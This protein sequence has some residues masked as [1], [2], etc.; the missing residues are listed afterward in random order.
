MPAVQGDR[1]CT[2]RDRRRRRGRVRLV[3]L[4]IDTSLGTPS[5]YGVLSV[6]TVIL[7]AGG[8]ARETLMGPQGKS[9]YERTFAPY[10]EA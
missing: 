3:K 7:F 5:R 8:E 2:D 10:L 1:A 4:D 6:P 9:K